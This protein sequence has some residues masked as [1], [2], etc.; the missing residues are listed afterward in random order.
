MLVP[1]QSAVVNVPRFQKVMLRAC[2]SRATY[3]RKPVPA[4]HTAFTAI[5]AS[6]SVNTFTLPNVDDT[7]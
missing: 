4:P 5:P 6:S 7:R 3:E 1:R 2:G